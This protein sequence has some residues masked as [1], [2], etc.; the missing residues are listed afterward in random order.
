MTPEPPGACIGGERRRESANEPIE[1]GKTGGNQ[2][3]YRPT[4][5]LRQSHA[6]SSVL[7][8][9]KLAMN[10]S[11]RQPMK[12]TN[13]NDDLMLVLPLLAEFRSP[14]VQ[15]S[16]G[17]RLSPMAAAT[18]V[19][20]C[21]SLHDSDWPAQK[22]Q[23]SRIGLGDEK[24]E[25]GYMLTDLSWR[26]G[27]VC[28]QRAPAFKSSETTLSWQSSPL[29]RLASSKHAWDVEC[30]EFAADTTSSVEVEP[31]PSYIDSLSDDPPPYTFNDSSPDVSQSHIT[32]RHLLAFI[33]PTWTT[34][35]ES[36][37]GM[38][39]PGLDFGDTSSFRQVAKKKKGGQKQAFTAPEDEGS[40]EPAGGEDNS[41]GGGTGGGAGGGGHNGDGGAGGDD[42]GGDGWD[43]GED[44]LNKGK[45]KKGKKNKGGVNEDEEKKKS[46][47]ED[48]EEEEKERARKQQED[49][50][51]ANAGDPLS[52]A[53]GDP[54]PN[55]EWADFMTT[56]KK[57]KKNKKGKA[58]PVNV[59][60][61]ASKPSESGAYENIDL[62]DTP[63]VNVDFG[64][65]TAMKETNSSFGFGEWGSSWDTS[66]LNGGNTGITD[67]TENTKNT[68]MEE[69]SFWPLGLGSKNK[70]KAA[71]PELE[72]G[73]FSATMEPKEELGASE[74]VKG[75][76]NDHW[77]KPAPPAGKKDKKNKKKGGYSWEDTAELVAVD[78]S[79]T[80]PEAFGEDAP[81]DAPWDMP[82]TKATKKK[83]KKAEAESK[84]S[85][86]SPVSP[87]AP[88]DEDGPTFG[89]KDKKKKHKAIIEVVENPKELDI[90]EAI[91]PVADADDKWGFRAKKDKKKD[92][93]EIVE[94]TVSHEDPAADQAAES[95]AEDF[96]WGVDTKKSPTTTK[97]NLW[98]DPY[99]ADPASTVVPDPATAE[100]SWGTGA[101]KGT[102][103]NK[104]NA[105][106]EPRAAEAP[107]VEPEQQADHALGFKEDGKKKPKKG[108]SDGSD[109][110]ANSVFAFQ[111]DPDPE[112]EPEAGFGWGFGTKKESKKKVKKGGTDEL[113]KAANPFGA[114]E[115]EHEPEPDLQAEPDWGS[116]TKKDGKKKTKKGIA[117]E[118]DKAAD[119]MLAFE[120]EHE[121]EPDLQ[122]EP[123]W[124]STTKKDGK[125]KTKK[126]IADESDKAADPMLAFENELLGEQEPGWGFETTKKDNKLGNVT[127]KKNSKKGTFEEHDHAKDPKTSSVTKSETQTGF[128]WDFGTKKDN[129]KK[130]QKSAFDFEE[131]DNAEDHAPEIFSPHAEPEIPAKWGTFGPQTSKKK[132]KG[133]VVEE[134]KIPDQLGVINVPEQ[135]LVGEGM[136]DTWGMPTKKDK[137][138]KK[139]QFEV[140]E[141]PMGPPVTMPVIDTPNAFANDN[142]QDWGGDKKKDKKAKKGTAVDAK[143]DESFSM[144]PP[145]Q[146]EDPEIPAS[147]DF[148]GK[149]KKGKKS[150]VVEPEP[151]PAFNMN[152]DV[153]GG[154]AYPGGNDWGGWGLSAKDTTNEKDME[155]TMEWGS[156]ANEHNEMYEPAE[157]EKEK[158]K[159]SK[160]KDKEKVKPGKKGKS[161]SSAVSKTKDLMA[162][163]T[164]D[165]IP[166]IEADNW[167]TSWAAPKSDKKPFG[168]KDMFQEAP[169]PAPTPPAQGFTPEPTPSP[170]P[171]LDDVGDADWGNSFAPTKPK[172]KKDAKKLTKAEESKSDNKAAK[173]K[174][175]GLMAETTKAKA[176]NEGKKGAAKDETPAKVARGFWGSMGLTATP[177]SQAIEEE[178]NVDDDEA[179]ADYKDEENYDDEEGDETNDLI[180]FKMG[181]DSITDLM[182]E[183]VAKGSKAKADGNGKLG[184]VISKESDKSSKI[185]ESKKKKGEKGQANNSNNRGLG[186]VMAEVAHVAHVAEVAPEITEPN[187][188]AN[189]NADAWSFWG[190]A[191]KPTGKKPEKSEKTDEPKKEIT[192]QSWT[193][194]IPSLN[195]I[196]NQPE[197]SFFD[198]QPRPPEPPK[199]TKSSKA[200]TSTMKPSAK[201]TVAQRVKA[202]EKE[203][204]EKEKEKALVPIS[205]P[206]LDPFEPLTKFD[207]PP[208]KVSPVGKSNLK[209]APTGKG[210]AAASK[211]KDLSPP[212]PEETVEE[213]A[214]RDFVPGSFPAEGAD[215]DITDVTSRLP[216]AGKANKKAPK[217][218]KQANMNLMDLDTPT[219]TPP[220]PDISE[221]ADVPE[222]P[223]TPPPEPVPAKPAKKERARVRDEGISSWGFWGATTK[224]PAKKEAKAKDDGDVPSTAA[225]ERAPVTGLVRSKSTKTT[226]EK[227]SEKIS[228][229]SSGSDKDRKAESRPAK[230]RGSSFGGFF[231]GP[232]PARAR[233]PRRQSV[234]TSKNASRR[235]SVDAEAMGLPSPP[236]EV[237][238]EMTAKAA[239]VMGTGGGKSAKEFPRGPAKASGIPSRRARADSIENADRR[240]LVVPDPY[241]ID[242]DDMVMVGGPDYPIVSDP[243]PKSKGVR[244][245]KSANGKAKKEVRSTPPTQPGFTRS[246]RSP[247][248]KHVPDEWSNADV[249]LNLNQIK[250][251][252]EPDDVVMVEA[253]PSSDGA[254][255]PSLQEA[256]AFDEPPS[257][258][259]PLQRSPTSAKRTDNKLM[260]L[261]GL[262]KTRR[263]SDMHE[264]PR[265][266]A[267]V[268]DD[269]N[270]RRKR[271][272]GGENDAAKRV[273]RDDRKVRRSERPD[274][275][276]D[277]FV[278]D[279]PLV[280]EAPEEV[281]AKNE[282]RRSKRASRSRPAKEYKEPRAREDTDQRAQQQEADQAQDDVRRAKARESRDR[283]TR[284]EDEEAA[285]RKADRRARQAAR[286]ERAMKDEPLARDLDPSSAYEGR[287]KRRDRD[288]RDRDLPPETSSRP[289]KSDR[290]RS[291]YDAPK[292]PGATE[293]R[294]RHD[295]RRSERRA[296]G[297]KS[298]S[299]RKSTA[300]PVDDYFDPRNGTAGD[301]LDPVPN[302]P[303]L[304]ST[305]RDSAP[306]EP[307]P[308]DSQEPYMHSG[309]NEHTSSWVK[310]QISEPP[311]PPP[312]EPS[313]LDPAPVLGGAA[314]DSTMDEDARRARRRQSRRKSR[315][316][317]GGGGGDGDG[318]RRRRR[319][320]RRETVRSSEGS[321]EQER[322]RAYG[323]RKSDYGGGVPLRGYGGGGGGMG[324]KRGSWFQKIKGL[325]EVR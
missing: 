324:T 124:G 101:K 59:S 43:G 236:P 187:A 65:K 7:D 207:S 99:G 2:E 265:T 120:N 68:S 307:N 175:G 257:A 270:L 289:R 181:G 193:N 260:G 286:E 56:G 78:D 39:T 293:R 255:L 186:N 184:K 32:L 38:T 254:E 251:A 108:A 10:P 128:D 183:P 189:H 264:R 31:P 138:S 266:K 240:H 115:N 41:G 20:A 52:W 74:D 57:G 76:G 292:S 54:N 42:G 246:K 296:P 267:Y 205:D 319:E 173:D 130:P 16:Q 127:N 17:D 194:P 153:M 166:I 252:P 90:K 275:D 191:K 147:F 308:L 121:P 158:E 3:S 230:P 192:K 180:D 164:P 218:R 21:D 143:Q 287:S 300:A 234:A 83:G 137:K 243:S 15:G 95:G 144:Q 282:D 261:F 290:R 185:S 1:G 48:E 210:A 55:D 123:D 179:D 211:K 221:V 297:E 19:S 172:G 13:G 50:G 182:D 152:N 97:K 244:N 219:P 93:K 212:T 245:D 318:E 168:R 321:A 250:T 69:S 51:T 33:D 171:G 37:P 91:E 119:P 44:D 199:T 258:P 277:G 295:E 154:D 316:A 159:A 323:R 129:K 169:P 303:P 177:K 178:E 204:L 242:D 73:D 29:E 279:A 217:P 113:D 302:P 85:E 61:P 256:L 239:K 202:L 106:D 81:A 263:V 75:E 268:D 309:A 276:A 80:E 237:V 45:K 165:P 88:G 6:T 67:I 214:F 156:Q 79:K 188:M 64:G 197:A 49:E 155:R 125:K 313:V 26:C 70:K 253:G 280:R 94:E 58:D 107:V 305:P 223:P 198:D 140:K 28:V 62:D 34:W 98:N 215:D 105:L 87:I 216:V 40:K 176:K 86:I 273:R 325:A 285:I 160:E 311:P 110:V 146:L 92:K 114:F 170:L 227:E 8:L 139:G 206:A 249:V 209:V 322:D 102:K 117:D 27:N 317:D 304:D 148:W 84:T 306:L 284:R 203:R 247:S 299:H 145:S 5:V 298:S 235:Q 291:H 312:L 248:D 82:A 149:E 228:A 12:K 111:A 96:N 283:R 208:K 122:A 167:G 53:N 162:N 161:T 141:A 9:S 229:K 294:P 315:Y 269:V 134:T 163:S 314:D 232:P 25:T 136:A 224:K 281:E 116:T 133:G 46:Q 201:T 150:K 104:K 151:D 274:T 89:K 278:A 213:N 135:S 157:K 222:A 238:P 142:W 112:F 126:G 47:E 22:I 118:S 231:G 72:F 24:R 36:L 63:K 60:L 11:V 195:E 272:V 35:K 18:I 4:P 225:K 226:K 131:V 30:L 109:K 271:T 71:S 196:S 288:T 233:P 310:S 190:T 14:G 200:A 301:I 23:L 66:G 320:S 77:T 259:A 103:K 220:I 174:A 132:G 241:A 262:R 100:I